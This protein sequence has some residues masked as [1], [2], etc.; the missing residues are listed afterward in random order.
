VEEEKRAVK[1]NEKK[2]KGVFNKSKKTP[3]SP[4]KEKQEKEKEGKE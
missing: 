1:G 3:R 4:K 2:R